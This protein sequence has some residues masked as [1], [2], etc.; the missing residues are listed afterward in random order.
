M[1]LEIPVNEINLISH[2]F[3][4]KENGLM[5]NGPLRDVETFLCSFIKFCR[6]KKL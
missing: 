1:S 4:Q 5:E 2:L 3:D 6:L